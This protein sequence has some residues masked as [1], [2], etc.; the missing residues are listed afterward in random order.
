[1]AEG[2]N[3]LET[4]E[5]AILESGHTTDDVEFIGDSRHQCDMGG[6]EKFAKKVDVVCRP[7]RVAE[8]LA[9]F[10]SDGSSLVR[11]VFE[12]RFIG[13]AKSGKRGKG[14]KDLSLDDIFYKPHAHMGMMMGAVSATLLGYG[15]DEITC[16]GDDMGAFLEVA[17]PCERGMY[18][19]VNVT[20]DINPE[21][22]PSIF[23]ADME[24]VKIHFFY[25]KAVPREGF[26][27]P[28]EQEDVL[29]R[30]TSVFGP[31]EVEE[32][33]KRFLEDVG[34]SEVG[35]RVG[36]SYGVSVKKDVEPED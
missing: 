8:G 4:T 12:W 22:D 10:F 30:D 28:I 23:M 15:F 16:G 5:K 24:K 33:L 17:A 7:D 25:E 36:D 26:F 2:E 32:P 19:R 31:Y 34:F 21:S 18:R 29:Y 20:I 13:S 3:F 14:T 35:Y 1:M 9:I 6:W 11:H 27:D